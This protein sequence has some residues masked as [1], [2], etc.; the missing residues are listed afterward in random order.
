VTLKGG[1]RGTLVR[2]TSDQLGHGNSCRAEA[3]FY[4]SKSS[5]QGAGPNSKCF[6]FWDP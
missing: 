4:L 6:Q 5:S 2:L 1:T 3:C